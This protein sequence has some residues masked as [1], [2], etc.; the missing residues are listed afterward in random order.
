MSI[1]MRAGHFGGGTSGIL[2]LKSGAF[3]FLISGVLLKSGVVG[4]S[5]VV[6]R[7]SGGVFGGV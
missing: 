6:G 4:N 7:V 1:L 5:G 2:K 3:G